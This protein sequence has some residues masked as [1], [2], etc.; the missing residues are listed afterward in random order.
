MTSFKK[1]NQD[2]KHYVDEPAVPIIHRT[3]HKESLINFI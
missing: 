2:L 1:K 3:G